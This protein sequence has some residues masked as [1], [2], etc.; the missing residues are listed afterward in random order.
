MDGGVETGM[1]PSLDVGTRKLF[2]PLDFA[3]F[4]DIGWELL[5]E[6]QGT[7]S[8]SHVYADNG[9][10]T[11]TTSIEE[12]RVLGS[13]EQTFEVTVENVVPT[14]AAI[15]DLTIHAGARL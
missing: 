9:T 11:V 4:D 3:A 12:F 2:T 15:D 1:D 8:G 10:Y 7:I 13:T 6:A 14:L 5:P